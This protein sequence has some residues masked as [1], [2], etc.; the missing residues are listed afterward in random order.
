MHLCQPYR[1]RSK[2]VFA[3]Q[4][5][6]FFNTYVHLVVPGTVEGL[7]KNDMASPHGTREQLCITKYGSFNYLLLCNKP[8]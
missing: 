7:S 2:Q 1:G 5:N 6:E 3:E 4:L 8:P